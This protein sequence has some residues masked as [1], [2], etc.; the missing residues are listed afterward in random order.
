MMLIRSAL[1]SFMLIM[2]GSAQA[3]CAFGKPTFAEEWSR[4]KYV[5]VGQLVDSKVLTS[6][7]DPEGVEAT[8][9][10]IKVV[11]SFKGRVGRKISI[12][13]DNTSS[14]FNMR[15]GYLYILFIESDGATNFVDPCG[16]SGEL[17]QRGPYE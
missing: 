12:R 6:V 16:S 5:I 7:D 2:C 1:I 15:A 9:Y 14:R 13:S 17:G 10:T 3:I 4:A 8:E 11:R